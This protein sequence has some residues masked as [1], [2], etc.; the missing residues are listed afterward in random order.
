MKLITL[1]NPRF[2]YSKTGSAIRVE[3]CVILA[4]ALLAMWSVRGACTAPWTAI[5]T[6][7][8]GSG[9]VPLLNVWTILWNVE[10]VGRGFSGYWNAPIFCP[11]T[12]TFA[13]SEPQIR[14]IGLLF[15]DQGADAP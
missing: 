3:L 7:R 9:T 13:F 1:L 11:L 14:D 8:S 4:S 2:I 12:G 5:P 10:S 6:T 15:A